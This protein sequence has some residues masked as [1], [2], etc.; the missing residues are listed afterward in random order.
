MAGCGLWL[1]PGSCVRTHGRVRH[2]HGCCKGTCTHALLHHLQERATKSRPT[3]CVRN[4]HLQV[5]RHV[6]HVMYELVDPLADAGMHHLKQ[7]L[8][9]WAA[10]WAC[11]CSN[12]KSGQWGLV[13]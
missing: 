4:A 2:E 9:G 10:G 3:A 7:A 1:E 8:G 13:R 6:V 12:G 5:G 11:T